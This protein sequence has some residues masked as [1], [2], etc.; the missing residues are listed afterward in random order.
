MA[1]RPLPL[2]RKPPLLYACP[3]SSQQF[4]TST[5]ACTGSGHVG[6]N[7][8]SCGISIKP[9][10]IELVRGLAAHRSNGSTGSPH[11]KYGAGHE[12]PT[13]GPLTL[14]L[15]NGGPAWLSA[16]PGALSLLPDA[17]PDSAVRCT[18][19]LGM[20]VWDRLAGARAY[21]GRWGFDQARHW[22]SGLRRRV[23]CFVQ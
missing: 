18:L 16:P 7:L 15:S 2:G 22:C 8:L 17:L 4:S 9:V 23:G 1:P 10:A 19:A 21:Q 14:R 12:R 11:I 5:S 13:G 20:P 6:Q 3:L